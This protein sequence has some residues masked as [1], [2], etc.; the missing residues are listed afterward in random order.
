[1]TQNQE[2]SNKEKNNRCLTSGGF[3]TWDAETTAE[4]LAIGGNAEGILSS[5]TLLTE[6]IL[7]DEA[8][9]IVTA[10]T[11]CYAPKIL[12]SQGIV[13]C[14]NGCFCAISPHVMM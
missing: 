13:C 10:S 7:G 1:M 12:L 3:L 4:W 14:K 9:D 5:G 6:K 8:L 11:A 2:Y